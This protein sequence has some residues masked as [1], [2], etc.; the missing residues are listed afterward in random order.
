LLPHHLLTVPVHDLGIALSRNDPFLSKVHHVR[1][2]SFNNPR[3]LDPIDWSEDSDC[4]PYVTAR[5]FDFEKVILDLP[6]SRIRLKTV[7][8]PGEVRRLGKLWRHLE[9]RLGIFRINCKDRGIDVLYED[10]EK[11][12]FDSIV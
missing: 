9:L 11:R 10:R 3:R 2:T 7:F 8:L 1:L 12:T 6:T 4:G 5:V